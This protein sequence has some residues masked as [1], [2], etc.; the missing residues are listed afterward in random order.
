MCQTMTCRDG[1]AAD[2]GCVASLFTA[3]VHGLAGAAYTAAQRSAWAP[4]PPDVQAWAGRISALTVRLAEAHGQL[5]GFIGYTTQGHI[6]LLFT[7]PDQARRG[8]AQQLYREAEATLRASGVR[9]L[10]TDA[11]L[12]ATPFFLRQ[13]FVIDRAETVVR[14]GVSLSRNHMQKML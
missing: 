7:A 6:D 10:T 14:G 13:G 9:R 2:A 3:S 5:L 1:C 8:V 12:V 11:S 4:Q